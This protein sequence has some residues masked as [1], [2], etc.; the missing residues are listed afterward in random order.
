[1]NIENKIKPAPL[2]VLFCGGLLV[3]L[4]LVAYFDKATGG[5]PSDELI[6]S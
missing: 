1:M 3:V 4:S 5:V 2:A 6:F